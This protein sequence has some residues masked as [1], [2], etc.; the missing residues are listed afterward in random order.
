MATPLNGADMG[1]SKSSSE[2]NANVPA[3]TESASAATLTPK[4]RSCI[5]CRTRKVRC[6]KQSPCSTCR[7]AN[8]P[9][10]L[11]STNRPPKWARRLERLTTNAGA[12]AAPIP[13]DVDPGVN[14]VMERVQTL[15]N[16]VKELRGQL[17]QTQAANSVGGDSPGS[18]AHHHDVEHQRD[19][20]PATD[21]SAVQQQIGRLVIQDTNRSHYVSGGF[22]SW[23]NDE[24]IQLIVT[25][26]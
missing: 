23:V 16:L 9:C 1:V 6:D 21:T 19:I 4:K 8:I 10:V 3:S 18:S 5:V 26:S 24:V 2:K 12:T 11:P 20:S 7:R 17:E 14:K 13:Q 15:E 25:M 22:W